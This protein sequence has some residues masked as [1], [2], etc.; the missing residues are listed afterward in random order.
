MTCTSEAT[1]SF[2]TP[3]SEKLNFKIKGKFVSCIKRRKKE[4]V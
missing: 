4:N 1:L 2:N 3:F